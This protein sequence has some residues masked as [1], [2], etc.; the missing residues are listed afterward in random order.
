MR[1]PSCGAKCGPTCERCPRCGG[2]PDPRTATFGGAARAVRASWGL[3]AEETGADTRPRTPRYLLFVVAA[4]ALVAGVLVCA[5]VL[6]RTAAKPVGHALT[7]ENFADEGLLAALAPFDLDADG[8]ISPAEAAEVRLL[9]CSGMGLRSLEGI[10]LFVN[11]EALDASGNALGAADLSGCPRL[12][13][14]DLSDNALTS[15][16]LGG[17][18]SLVSLD[19]SDNALTVL[20]VASCTSLEDLSCSGN[21]LA[22]L[23]LGDCTALRSLSCDVGQNVTLPLAEGFFPDP[24][25]RAALAVCDADGNGALTLRER[26]A[27]T[28]LDLNGTDV[29]DLTGL[30]WFEN[31]AQLSAD[32]TQ[33]A[34]LS[35]SQLPAA[36]TALS[37]RGCAVA[38]V[39][40]TGAA[41]LT[42]LDL[43]GNPLE[44][45][46]LTG[47]AR[48]TSLNLA[49]CRLAGTLDVTAC[50]R[51]T[52]LDVTGNAGLATVDAR[53]AAGL[54][55]PGA[56][57]C[58]PGCTVLLAD[59]EPEP[60]PADA[61]TPETEDGAPGEP[62]DGAPGG[63]E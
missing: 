6:Q 63:T 10:Q 18:A 26:Q 7:A 29:A 58:D 15:L 61:E 43:A 51:L 8:S 19:V 45:V 17:H 49:N 25:L 57:S 62:A 34:A 12:V 35:A 54:A 5:L 40:M 11:L 27:L 60:A 28:A 16:D 38:A 42:T 4:L 52:A 21:S 47:A 1:C 9:D 39:D 44:T 48:L 20:G 33:L 13:A 23:D 32:G 53:D 56:V 41:R 30:L 59:P 37:A 3:T 50:P 36:L 31:L 24:V 2:I 14:V 22:R 46:V 55:L